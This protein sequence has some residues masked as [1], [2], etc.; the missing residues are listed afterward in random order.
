[1]CGRSGVR[2][3]ATG[4]KMAPDLFM[5]IGSNSKTCACGRATS[6]SASCSRP[7]WRGERD[8]FLPAL[9]EGDG[10]LYGLALENQNGW[11]TMVVALN[12]G[13]NIPGSWAMMQEI[14]RIIRPNHPWPGLPKE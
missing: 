11:I 9:P 1:M 8:R 6:P 4:E 3:T 12:S 10:S 5:R 13:A 7:R 2:D 14:I